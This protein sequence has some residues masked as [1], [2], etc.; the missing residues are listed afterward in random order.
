MWPGW[1]ILAPA[2]FVLWSGYTLARGELR[3]EAVLYFVGAPALAFATERTKRIFVGAYP[4]AMVGVTYDAMRFVTPLGLAPGRLHACDLQAFDARVFGVAVGGRAVSWSD[5][6]ARYD[7]LPLDL[8][9]AIPYGTFIF[10]VVGYAIWLFTR[11]DAR[12]L[13]RFAW[14]FFVVNVVGFATYHVVPAAPPWYVHAHGCALD[15]SVRASCGPKL[16]RVDA[17]LGVPYFRGM[18]GRASEV[19]GAFPS[20]H[21]SYPLLVVLE[22][23]RR[24]GALGRGLS[25]AFAAS[26]AFAAVWLDHHWVTDVAAGALYGVL[27]YAFVTHF[28]FPWDE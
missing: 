23:W 4:A 26:M 28:F 16:A 9:C 1:T 25:V 13:S 15:P 19:F 24:H 14:A 10:V 27:A 8:Y 12:G 17:W 21:T 3:W 5:L 6:A 2:P 18:Y 7:A 22:G 11:D 20:L